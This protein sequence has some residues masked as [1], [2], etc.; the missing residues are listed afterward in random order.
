MGRKRKPLVRPGE[1]KQKTRKGLEIPVPPRS[2]FFGM[3]D[4]TATKT[5]RERRGKASH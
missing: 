2:E 4:T 1:R 5:P 3:L